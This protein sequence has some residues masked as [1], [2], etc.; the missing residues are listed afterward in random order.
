MDLIDTESDIYIVTTDKD[1]NGDAIG[2]L[3]LGIFSGTQEDILTYINDTIDW[4]YTLTTDDVYFDEAT[5]H[6]ISTP[7]A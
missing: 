2:H 5:L 3:T 1:E 7:P 6:T 4:E